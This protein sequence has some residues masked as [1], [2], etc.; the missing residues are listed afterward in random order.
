MRPNNH[1]HPSIGDIRRNRS[2]P[3]ALVTLA[4]AIAL[5]GCAYHR[6]STL[7]PKPPDQTYHPVTSNA[8]FWGAIDD[9]RKA[10]QCPTSLLSEVRVRTSLAHAL[11]T[12]LTLG[13]WQPS[14][15]EYRCSK[16]PTAEGEIKP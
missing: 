13:F 6:L 1:G 8:V 14:R 4:A 9:P 16:L 3:R 2:M 7:N 10:E 5:Q 12:V 11:A 15:I